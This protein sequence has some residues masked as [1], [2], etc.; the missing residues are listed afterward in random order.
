MENKCEV[1]ESMDPGSKCPACEKVKE[2]PPLSVH[3]NER[4]GSK[5]K[6]G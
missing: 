4:A 5:E 6:V 3:V 1:C 2:L